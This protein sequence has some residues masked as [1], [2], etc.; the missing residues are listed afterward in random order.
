MPGLLKSAILRHLLLLLLLSLLSLTQSLSNSKTSV[1]PRRLEVG[2]KKPRTQQRIVLSPFQLIHS[3]YNCL[4]IGCNRGSNAR[5]YE[6]G[7]DMRRSLHVLESSKKES[8]HEQRISDRKFLDTLL[9]K[10]IIFGSI[11]RFRSMLPQITFMLSSNLRNFH[12]RQASHDCDDPLNRVR[13]FRQ[14]PLRS[15][16]IAYTIYLCVG[17][18]AYKVVFPEVTWSVLDAMYFSSVCLSTIGYGDLVPSTNNGKVFAAIFGMSGI[19]L[20][21]SAIAS[22]G[23]KL[24]QSETSTAKKKIRKQRKK[25]LMEFY[26]QLLPDM[27]KRAREEKKKENQLDDEHPSTALEASWPLKSSSSSKQS[28]EEL[29]A[30]ERKWTFLIRTLVR[31]LLVIVAGGIFIGKLEGWNLCDSFYFSL[32]SASTIGFGDYSPTTRTGRMASIFLIPMFLAAAGD[33]FARVGIFVIRNRTKQLFE[34]Q[35]ERAEWLTE[36]QANEMD[37]DGNGSVSKAEYVLYMLV[38][39]GIVSKDESLVL[40]EQF[41]RFDVTRSGHIESGD[42]KAMKKFREKLRRERSKEKRIQESQR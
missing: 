31:P 10:I 13:V 14:L 26:E 19:L 15:A 29:A 27:L 18:L 4:S 9:L 35:A 11:K 30:G 42:L 38:E 24:V 23:T 25:A 34:S 5:N 28:T 33:F 3:H 40:E 39:A 8:S 20:W 21:S 36:K 12:K 1:S 37:L 41:E 6:V 17:V 16:C 22:V 32:V 7:T 2:A